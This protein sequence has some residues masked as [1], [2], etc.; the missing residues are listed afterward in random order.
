MDHVFHI[1]PPNQIH[2][3][4]GLRLLQVAEALEA[5]EEKYR[6][7]PKA[8]R[9]HPDIGCWWTLYDYD[10]EAV[11]AWPVDYQHPYPGKRVDYQHHCA[12]K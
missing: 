10:L 4:T 2:G 9:P 11:K 12:G 1:R 3:C 5:L 7:F 8:S 6:D